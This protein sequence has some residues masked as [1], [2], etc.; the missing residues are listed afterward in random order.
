MSIG[1]Q[2]LCFALLSSWKV[3][4]NYFL[5]LRGNVLGGAGKL[6]D[7]WAMDFVLFWVFFGV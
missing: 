2:Q 5:I 3:S 7:L 4:A 6:P 1:N